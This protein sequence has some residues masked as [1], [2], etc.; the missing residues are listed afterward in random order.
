MTTKNINSK[1][2]PVQRNLRLD[3][4]LDSLVVAAAKEANISVNLWI[5]NIIADLAK[6]YLPEE[7]DN[8]RKVT[9]LQEAKLLCQKIK[10]RRIY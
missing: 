7:E 9:D 1:E 4:Q 6:K 8:F 10:N 3:P 2:K 5:N